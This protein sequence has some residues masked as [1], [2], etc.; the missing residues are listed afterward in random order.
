MPEV[1]IVDDHPL[2][3]DAVR[4]VFEHG[5]DWSVSDAGSYEDALA[6]MIKVPVPD[7]V[8]LDLGLPGQFGVD[9]LRNFREK[10]PESPCVVLSGQDDSENVHSAIELGA[11]GF[12]S[13]RSSGDAIMEA[14]SLVSKGYICTP[15]EAIGRSSTP[16]PSTNPMQLGL[17]GRQCEVLSQL[18]LGKSNKAIARVLDLTEATV[19]TH[20]L[21]IFRVLD[22]HNRTGAVMAV[23][24]MGLQLSLFERQKA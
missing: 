2:I 6:R 16:R 14:I 20:V 10:F 5:G 17:T 7:L 12:I 13:K 4:R 19:K 21:A 22:V 23:S 11:M 15:R 24:R 9:A 1:L 3:R 18:V 8:L